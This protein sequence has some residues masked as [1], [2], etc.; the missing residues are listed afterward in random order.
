MKALIQRVKH[1][2]VEVS[3]KVTGEISKGLLI[4]L[5]ITNS[6]AEA[7]VNFL[8]DKIANLRIFED[9]E[10]KMNLS[11]LEI[12]GEVLIVSQFTLYADLKKG[13]RPSFIDAARPELAEGLYKK[14]IQQFG[15]TGLKC[16]QGEFGAMMDVELI[17]WGPVTIMLDSKE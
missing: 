1:A 7:D 5:G 14:F 4:L 9:Q 3:G 10:E 16:A 6:D 12:K 13:R 11:L 8:V 2:K 15:L 17:N